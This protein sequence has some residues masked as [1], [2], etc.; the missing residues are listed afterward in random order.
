MSLG[1]LAVG[2]LILL[3]A[4]ALGWAVERLLEGLLHALARRT[5]WKWDDVLARSLRWVLVT[6]ISIGT[7]FWLL[8]WW[9]LPERLLVMADRVLL[10]AA[11]AV[12]FIWVFRVAVG[13]FQLLLHDSET[14]PS[15]SILVNIVRLAV[16]SIAAVVILQILGVPITPLL[17]ALGVGGLAIALALQ[18]TLSN[19]FAGLH[20]LAARQVRPGDFVRLV[21]SG[22]EGVVQDIN[23]R[24]TTVRALA[25]FF[26]IVPNSKLANSIVVNYQLP[27]SE[28]SITV[29]VSVSYGSDL[30][31]VE[32]VTLAVAR[33]VQAEVPGAVRDFEPLIRFQ[34]FGGDAGIRFAVSLRVEQAESQYLVRH[35]FIKRLFAAYRAAGI[36]IPYPT[37]HVVGSVEV[38]LASDSRSGAQV[39]AQ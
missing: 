28:M 10:V 14:L 21:D 8:R 29:P 4:G 36:E 6:G 31:K 35:E 27:T 13:V 16:I 9:Q 26:V 39:E 20:I 34:D 23:W 25:D 15:V 19:L 1:K 5:R 7:L 37:R 33:Q 22:L 32:Q 30:E 18:D 38:Q 17:T 12:G 11:L 2:F 24:N 3:G